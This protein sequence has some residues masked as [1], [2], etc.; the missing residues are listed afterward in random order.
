MLLIDVV[1]GTGSICRVCHDFIHVCMPSRIS[2]YLVRIFLFEVPLHSS[3]HYFLSLPRNRQNHVGEPFCEHLVVYGVAG[4][5]KE[6]IPHV[7]NVSIKP[8]ILLISGTNLLECHQLKSQGLHALGLKT[9][10]IIEM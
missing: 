2:T 4:C 7:N 5:L 9:S 3:F 8:S 1:W 6:L 10:S